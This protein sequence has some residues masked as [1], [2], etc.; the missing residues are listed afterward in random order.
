LSVAEY[1][2]QLE[3]LNNRAEIPL[4]AS[5][6]AC[7]HAG[8]I[9]YRKR[10]KRSSKEEQAGSFRETGQ[11]QLHLHLQGE[12]ATSAV[13][14]RNANSLIFPMFCVGCFAQEKAL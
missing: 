3:E 2:S 4:A 6:P 1:S 10:L 8:I 14:V 5:Q 11:L 7:L 9:M 13:C 12:R